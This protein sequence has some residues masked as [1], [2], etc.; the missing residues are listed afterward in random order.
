MS[1]PESKVTGLRWRGGTGG[2]GPDGWVE[3]ADGE[4][5]A[6]PS[7]PPAEMTGD[8]GGILAT[9]GSCAVFF[10]SYIGFEKSLL[11]SSTPGSSVT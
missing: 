4:I 3:K 6:G 5:V 1:L 7:S 2:G 11:E 10:I 8:A 9:G